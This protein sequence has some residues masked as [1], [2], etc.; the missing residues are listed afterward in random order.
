MYVGRHP[1]DCRVVAVTC[2]GVGPGPALA[3]ATT[4]TLYSVWGSNPGIVY[5]V[6]QLPTVVLSDSAVYKSKLNF[7][8][9]LFNLKLDSAFG[10]RATSCHS[11]IG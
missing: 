9:H 11:I 3:V 1:P 10:H 2:S 6:T 7:H 8:Q 4:V 5:S